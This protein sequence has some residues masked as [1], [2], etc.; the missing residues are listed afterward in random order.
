M[1]LPAEKGQKSVVRNQGPPGPTHV[2]VFVVKFGRGGPGSAWSC[3]CPNFST[4]TNA[5]S[6][7]VGGYPGQLGPALIPTP[8]TQGPHQSV[9]TSL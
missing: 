8:T 1:S 7:L 4:L 9:E 2:V 6:Q 3:L 5:V